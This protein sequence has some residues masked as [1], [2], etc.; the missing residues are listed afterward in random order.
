[1]QGH[2]IVGIAENGL[3]AIALIKNSQPDCAILDIN[4]P[5]ANGAEVF[6]EARRW[7]AKTQF[8]ILTAHPSANL[9]STLIEAGVS[10]IFLKSDDPTEVCKGIARMLRGQTVL[11]PSVV[12][13]MSP[14]EQVADLTKREL[15]VLQGIARGHSNATMAAELGIS[16]K[17]V[18][19]HRTN[20]MNKLSVHSSATL[21]M[22]AVKLGLIGV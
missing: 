11:S 7:S 14:E 22:K 8:V 16:A 12:Q 19:T 15:Q 2:E 17:T 4:M 9:F 3:D 21:L 13:V 1:M 6:L 10:G 5:G 18:D 20:L